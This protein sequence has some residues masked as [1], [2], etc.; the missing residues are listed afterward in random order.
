MRFCSWF[1]EEPRYRACTNAA[2]P[3]KSRCAEHQIKR[4]QGDFTAA[5]RRQVVDLY[6]GRCAVCG[7]PGTEVDHIVELAEFQPH[8]RWQANLISNLQLLCFMHHSAK[9]RAYNAAEENPNDY[10]RSARSRKRSRMRR[11]NFGV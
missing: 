5:I 9:T 8:E 3:G 2:L 6:G 1:T 11:N 10:H 4:R 7:E